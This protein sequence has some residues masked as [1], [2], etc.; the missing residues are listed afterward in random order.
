MLLA[1]AV[2]RSLEMR[3]VVQDLS[4][5]MLAMIA[6]AAFGSHFGGSWGIEANGIQFFPGAS[7]AE[8][9]VHP[10]VFSRSGGCIDVSSIYGPGIGYRIEEIDRSLPKRAA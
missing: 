2:A 6:H 7:T 3:V 10:G 8:S 9:R 1:I 4:N 5:T